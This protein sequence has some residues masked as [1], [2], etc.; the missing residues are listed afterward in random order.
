MVT[1]TMDVP[2]DQ[3]RQDA[4]LARDVLD[5]RGRRLLSAGTALTPKRLATLRRLR[6]KTVPVE[7]LLE[8]EEAAARRQAI[9]QQLATRFRKL[10]DDPLMRALK[11]VLLDYRLE[12]LK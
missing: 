6:I 1:V 10:E 2:L 8:P 11:D 5:A 7:V 4:S 12:T 3:L 9:E